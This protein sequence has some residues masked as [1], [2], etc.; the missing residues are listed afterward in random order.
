MLGYSFG[1]NTGL[2]YHPAKRVRGVC[3]RRDID[4]L[5]LLLKVS[6]EEWECAMSSV[7]FRA[8]STAQ[9]RPRSQNLS[10]DPGLSTRPDVW[11][12]PKCIIG[13]GRAAYRI[14]EKVL[15]LVTSR[16][17]LCIRV[18]KRCPAP[19]PTTRPNKHRAFPT[20][21]SFSCHPNYFRT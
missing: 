1:C 17:G 18:L 14:T 4:S 16:S 9:A 2:A 19:H 12:D 11:E 10:K 13:P 21:I 5:G 3:R 20:T 15:T 8:P 6:M 7:G